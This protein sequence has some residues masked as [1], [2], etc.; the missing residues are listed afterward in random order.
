M[1]KEPKGRLVTDP[2]ELRAVVAGMRGAGRIGFDTEFVGER[3]YFPRL[4]LIQLGTEDEVFAVDPLAVGDLSPLD[5]LLF[6]PS[7][8]KLVHAGWQDL[9]I[10]F[11]RT[12]R[13]PAPVFD[14]QIA[15]SVLGL[16][17]QAAYAS[18]VRE[19]LAGRREEGALLFRLVRPAAVRVAAR[20]RPRRRPLPPRAA[21]PD[22]GAARGRKGASPGSSTEMSALSSPATYESDPEEEY[23]RVKGWADPRPAVAW[24][25]CGG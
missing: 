24:P 13:V 15:A 7:I 19:F 11:Q 6:D 23:R 14:V 20:V 1:D 4:C 18:V 5:E 16:P 8:L 21:R 10:I 3:T 12:G 17:A 22:D 2:A 25:C 9:K